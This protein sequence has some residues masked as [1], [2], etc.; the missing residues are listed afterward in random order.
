MAR[1]YHLRNKKWQPY[2]IIPHYTR[3]LIIHG[4]ENCGLDFRLILDYQLNEWVNITVPLDAA[5]NNCRF[6]LIVCLHLPVSHKGQVFG[7]YSTIAAKYCI[8]TLIA[9]PLLCKEKVCSWY[10]LLWSG[11]FLT[12]IETSRRMMNPSRAGLVY[13]RYV[14]KHDDVIKWKHFPRYWPFVRE[15]H[16][17]PV[18]SPHKGQWR[19]AL[20]FSLICAWINGRVKKSWG[21]WFETQSRSL[22]RKCN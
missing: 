3:F 13:I 8:I 20:M 21:W 4:V 5:K 15:I 17:S 2:A 19:G 10:G 1:R 18:N 9:V 12:C 14:N 16:R 22:W 7:K 6:V 11:A